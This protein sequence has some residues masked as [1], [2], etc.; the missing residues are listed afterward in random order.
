LFRNEPADDPLGL[1]A[2][3]RAGV[4]SSLMGIAA[5]HSIERGG[6]PV[7]IADLLRLQG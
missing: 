4:L 1:R 7:K 5:R 6:Q 2:G 3:L